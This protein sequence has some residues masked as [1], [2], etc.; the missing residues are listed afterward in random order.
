M[1]DNIAS[2][3]LF[4]T[5]EQ[6]LIPFIIF[7]YL[8]ID[9]DIF[10]NATCLILIGTLFNTALK[11][12]FQVP[13]AEILGKD[14]FA[15]PSGHMQAA[16]AFFGWLALKSHA[17]KIRIFTIILL[18]CI[19]LSLVHFQYHNYYDVL[20]AIFSASLLMYA[21]YQNLK[22]AKP[23]SQWIM[24]VSSSIFIAYIYF[25]VQR[26]NSHV[27]IAYYIL[28]SLIVFEKTFRNRLI[29]QLRTI[30]R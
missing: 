19:G 28:L 12:T 11:V 8:Y 27:W 5:N 24:I 17:F 26:I 23:I 20:A 3:F 9:R 13:L 22:I 7:G 25:R 21:Y 29:K 2:L 30:W 14:G 16:T 18:I 1:T 15:F 4:F 6:F 10:Y